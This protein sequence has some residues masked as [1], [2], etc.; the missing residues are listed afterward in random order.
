MDQALLQE[1]YQRYYRELYLYLLS[2][3]GSPPLAEDLIQET[4]LKAILSLPNSHANIRAW[5][6]LV[7]RNLWLNHRRRES[8]LTLTDQVDDTPV[9]DDLLER[10]LRD[11]RQRMLYRALAHLEPRKREI[12]QMQ[13]FGGLAQREIAAVLHL[14]PEHVRVLACRARKELKQWME[15]NGYDIS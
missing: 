5:L 14:T 7:A 9:E 15:E 11:E 3:S 4:F 13:Y 12:L 8:R 10:V 2:L 1:M 6:Y